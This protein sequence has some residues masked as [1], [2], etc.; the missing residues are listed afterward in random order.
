MSRTL[1]LCGYQGNR[2]IGRIGWVFALLAAF[3]GLQAALGTLRAEE[4]VHFPSQDADI[5]HGAP[6]MIEAKL[7]KPEGPGPFPAVVGLHGCAGR[8]A[9]DG[10]PNSRFRMWTPLLVSLGYVVLL[11]DSF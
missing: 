5:T 7:Y 2:S 10:R 4:S 11:P 6:T 3:L 8:D 9:K 1:L